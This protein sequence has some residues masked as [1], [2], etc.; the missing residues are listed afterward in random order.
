MY[1]EEKF[2]DLKDMAL[3]VQMAHSKHLN[4]NTGD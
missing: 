1:N 2:P 4:S 3:H